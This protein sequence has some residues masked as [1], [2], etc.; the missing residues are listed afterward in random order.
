MLQ[1]RYVFPIV[2]NY[3]Q[4]F[5]CLKWV[6]TA[7]GQK[8]EATELVTGLPSSLRHKNPMNFHAKDP[9]KTFVKLALL[10]RTGPSTLLP[11]I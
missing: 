7:F 11:Q 3:L 1:K 4:A 6:H 9:P 10:V 2:T 8:I 5:Y